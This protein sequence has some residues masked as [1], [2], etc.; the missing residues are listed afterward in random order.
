MSIDSV[1]WIHVHCISNCMVYCVSHW[2]MSTVWLVVLF[3]EFYIALTI[4]QIHNL[5]KRSGET[6]DRTPDPCSARAYYSITAIPSNVYWICIF[7]SVWTYGILYFTQR[8]ILVTGSTSTKF[9]PLHITS[10]N[11]PRT[12]WGVERRQLRKANTY[13]VTYS[14]TVSIWKVRICETCGAYW[15]NRWLKQIYLLRLLR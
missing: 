4:F 2:Q 11:T 14:L 3:L 12:Y 5:W 1:S 13:Q 15:P 10:E 7:L 9:D 6:R 8:S